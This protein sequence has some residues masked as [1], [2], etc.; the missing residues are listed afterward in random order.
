MNFR[1]FIYS[2]DVYV[3]RGCFFIDILIQIE[4]HIPLRTKITACI[5]YLIPNIP[6][7]NNMKENKYMKMV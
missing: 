4:K 6:L 1:E 2:H 7:C 3:D 5:H